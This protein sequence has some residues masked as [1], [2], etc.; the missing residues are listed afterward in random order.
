MLQCLMNGLLLTGDIHHA[1]CNYS[2][3]VKVDEVG[4]IGV[5]ATR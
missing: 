5:N 1:A 3:S 2:A 4:R